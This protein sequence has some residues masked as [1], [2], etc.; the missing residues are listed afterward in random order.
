MAVGTS[1]ASLG[2]DAALPLRSDLGV[3]AGQSVVAVHTGV[4]PAGVGW[5]IGV[6]IGS[7]SGV[8]V[9]SAAT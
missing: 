1:Y 9:G 4:D 7:V 5:T 3:L 6:G 8:A 2:V